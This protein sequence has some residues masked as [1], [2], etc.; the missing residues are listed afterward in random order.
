MLH[1]LIILF[2]VPGIFSGSVL[3]LHPENESKPSA[4]SFIQ[5]Y[6]NI[7]NQAPDWCMVWNDEF[8]TPQID[9]SK[10]TFDIGTGKPLSGWGNYELQ[11]YTAREKN[12]RIE[13]GRLIITAL[14]EDYGG[15]PYTAAKLKTLGL[16]A[17]T[18]GRFEIRARIPGTQGLWPAI[19]MMP[20]TARY[21]NWPRSGEIDI[22]EHLGQYPDLVHGNIHLGR[23][24]NEKDSHLGTY[25]LEEGTFNEQFFTYGLE[26]EEDE[27]RWYIDDIHYHTARPSDVPDYNWPFDD[28]FFLILNVAVGGS[29]PG[30]PDESSVFPALMEVEFVRVF[31]KCNSN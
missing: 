29:W 7:E 10:W 3:E 31:Q 22:M 21:G 5:D 17:W 16:A 19:W 20:T 12:A 8:D 23:A 25:R 13:N 14:K 9:R 27:I 30:S 11:Y 6:T 18:Y 2:L 28:K 15:K 26:W 4:N 24:W 1:T